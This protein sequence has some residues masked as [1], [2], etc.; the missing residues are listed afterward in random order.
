ME[1]TLR[2]LRRYS[3]PVK[4]Q[5][6]AT[7]EMG[8]GLWLSNRT[9]TELLANQAEMD[10]FGRFLIEEGLET[11]TFNGFPFGNFHQPVVKHGVY[12]PTWFEPERLKYTKSLA[13]LINRF[14]PAGD[15]SISTLPIVWG[16]PRPT[17]E[18]L[19]EAGSLLREIAQYLFEME[20]QTGRLIYIC[21]EPEPGC[22]L[23]RATDVIRFFEEHVFRPEQEYAI[24]RHIRVCHDV[25]HSVVMAEPQQQALS[26]YQSAGLF[27]GKIQISSAVVVDFDSIDKQDRKQAVAELSAFAEDR[28][29]HQ[30]TIQLSGGEPE[31]FEDLPLALRTIDNPALASGVWRIHFH[32]PIYLERFGLLQASQQAIIECVS[33]CRKYSDVKHFEVETYAWNVLPQELQQADL[34]AGISEEMQWF[35]RVA[36]QYLE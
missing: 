24:R 21:I 17:T 11:F 29:L 12:K 5:H 9:A 4:A 3:V 14:A 31:F 33:E 19:D 1:E 23:Q 15:A 8:V 16:N 36:K 2:N 32:I 18:Q 22:L 34:V 25:C 13:Q 26:T 30:T 6:S 7:T 27:V 35:K 10:S 20:Q 28:Y